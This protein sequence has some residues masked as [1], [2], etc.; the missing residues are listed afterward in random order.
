[1]L[2]I[3]TEL[4]RDLN[5]DTFQKMDFMKLIGVAQQQQKQQKQHK[6]IL[7][8][9]STLWTMCFVVEKYIDLYTKYMCTN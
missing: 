9:G 8:L 5:L 2:K 6:Y 4:Y 7:W 3:V 1:M